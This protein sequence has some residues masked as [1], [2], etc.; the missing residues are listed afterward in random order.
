VDHRVVAGE[1]PAKALDV[2]CPV[3]EDYR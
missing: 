1:Q 2:F 3:R